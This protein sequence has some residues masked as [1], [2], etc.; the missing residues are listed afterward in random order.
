MNERLA[1]A[2][3]LLVEAEAMKILKLSLPKGSSERERV[4]HE[5]TGMIKAIKLVLE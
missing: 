2:R 1:I 3:R 5:L 4:T